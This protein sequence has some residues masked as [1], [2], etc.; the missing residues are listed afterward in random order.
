RDFIDNSAPG[1][2]DDFALR[3]ERMVESILA[4]AESDLIGIQEARDNIGAALGGVL[5]R[6]L[7]RLLEPALSSYARVAILIDNLDKAWDKHADLDS[8]SHL[9]L[10]LLT[11]VGRVTSEFRRGTGADDLAFSLAVFLRYDIYQHLIRVAREP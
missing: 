8:F 3:L 2:R 10:G 1:I 6:D 4:K 11:S 9:L 5:V 7:R